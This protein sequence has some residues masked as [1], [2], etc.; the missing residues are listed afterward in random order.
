MEVV[1]RARRRKW[2]ER[3]PGKHGP[4]RFDDTVAVPAR[5]SRARCDRSEHSREQQGAAI[6]NRPSSFARRMS[7]EGREKLTRRAGEERGARN[8][9]EK[10]GQR[11]VSRARRQPGRARESEGENE[12][13]GATNRFDGARGS[14]R[15]RSRG[16]AVGRSSPEVALPVRRHNSLTRRH[17]LLDHLHLLLACVATVVVLQQTER[18]G[19]DR[20]GRAAV[21]SNSCAPASCHPPRCTRADALRRRAARRP[22]PP[23]ALV[24]MRGLAKKFLSVRVHGRV[25]YLRP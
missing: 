19:Q 5:M 24:A 18:Q 4:V 15:D 6:K 12:I 22:G 3:R 9:V 1:R 7:G 21:L 2:Q 10:P 20:H 16:A 23:G 25:T 8:R 13:G 11:E 14:A 17:H